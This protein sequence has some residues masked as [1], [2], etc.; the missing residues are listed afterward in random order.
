MLSPLVR[1]VSGVQME[2][3]MWGEGGLGVWMDRGGTRQLTLYI[4]Q[5]LD[6]LFIP[7]RNDGRI[8]N[9]R[10]G[11]RNLSKAEFAPSTRSNQLY[12]RIYYN[13]TV[14]VSVTTMFF[15]TA[16]SKFEKE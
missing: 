10:V 11:P 4:R 3:S 1:R 15:K 8:Q 12:T 14:E 16:T 5:V 6:N 9:E 7:L 13:T 2:V